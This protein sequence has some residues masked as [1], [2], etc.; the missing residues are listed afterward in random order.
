MEAV[1]NDSPDD[2]QVAPDDTASQTD[3]TT[4]FPRIHATAAQQDT[5][6]RTSRPSRPYPLRSQ[7][8]NRPQAPVFITSEESTNP[9]ALPDIN[10]VSLN[11]TSLRHLCTLRRLPTDG[12]KNDLINRLQSDAIQ[13]HQELSSFDPEATY[14]EIDTQSDETPPH[15][16]HFT[17][18]HHYHDHYP[19]M[20]PQHPGLCHSP[21]PACSKEDMEKIIKATV[22]QVT[23]EMNNKQNNDDT[24]WKETQLHLKRDQNEF[25]VL[26]Q[27]GRLL[28]AADKASDDNKKDLYKK[29]EDLVKNRAAT[30]LIANEFGWGAASQLTPTSRHPL[31]AGYQDRLTSL[32]TNKNNTRQ[33]N[34]RN[35]SWKSNEDFQRPPA[36]R[37]WNFNTSNQEP[38]TKNFRSFRNKTNTFYRQEPQR[39]FH[40]EGIGH[41]A[42]Q[43]PA[44]GQ[45]TQHRSKQNL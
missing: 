15:L 16:N 1:E 10:W 43:C 7:S 4:R 38:F 6:T 19:L 22:I 3:Q 26:L 32:S 18:S 40:C 39:C 36:K 24:P 35:S 28:E 23:K 30:L 45:Q 42:K 17:Q 2:G 14:N 21:A 13:T 31:L 25:D 8:V 9:S 11:L 44:K 29:I 37:P 12:S 20:H 33:F 41:F 27:V 34:Q 5:P